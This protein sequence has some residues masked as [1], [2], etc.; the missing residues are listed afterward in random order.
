MYPDLVH[1]PKNGTVVPNSGRYS[2]NLVHVP[3]IGTRPSTE[4][5]VADHNCWYNRALS[6]Q[7]RELEIQTK[8]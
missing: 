8:W 7:H 1:L 6:K 4:K 2:A 5:S 3:T